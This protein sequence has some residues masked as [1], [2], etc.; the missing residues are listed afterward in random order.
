[1]YSYYIFTLRDLTVEHM[2]A[3]LGIDCVS[4]RFAWKLQSDVP[5]TRQASYRVIL[6]NDG[7]MAAD[8]G[9]VESDA[10]IEV[11]VPGFNPKP[12]TRY[13]IKVT[14]TNNHGREAFLFSFAAQ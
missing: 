14:V 7:E 4:P 10:S 8:T 6:W 13:L 11:T 2:R 3:P 5:G 1:M 12:M 9:V